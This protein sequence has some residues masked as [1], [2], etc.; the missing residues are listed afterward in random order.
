MRPRT[1][2]VPTMTT[3]GGGSGASDDGKRWGRAE[4]AADPTATM[5]RRAADPVRRTT[6]SGGGSGATPRG[7]GAS[8]ND[9]DG[10]GVGESNGDNDNGRWV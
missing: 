5:T 4:G 3:A 7:S 9:D 2:P 1:D 10:W 8:N 6:G